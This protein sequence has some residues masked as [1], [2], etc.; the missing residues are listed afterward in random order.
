MRHI[1]TQMVGHDAAQRILGE[2][3]AALLDGLEHLLGARGQLF[4]VTLTREQ[5]FDG[6]LRTCAIEF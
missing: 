1:R 6:A 3:L 5:H 2:R 4:K